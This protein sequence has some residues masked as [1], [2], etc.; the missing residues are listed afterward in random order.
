MAVTKRYNPRRRSVWAVI[1]TRNEES[2]IGPLVEAIW[3]LGVGT[4]VVD[5]G[6]VDQTYDAAREA[7]AD[8][9]MLIPDDLVPYGIGPCQRIGMRKALA[10]GAGQVV[11]I[12]AGGSHDPASIPG[13]VGALKDHDMAI[14]SRFCVGGEYL[15]GDGP[16]WRPWGSRVAAHVMNLTVHG[17]KF[18]D[19]SS[20]F[21]AFRAPLVEQ[22]IRHR[23][24]GTMYGW[25]IEALARAVESGAKI[26]EV[27][28]TYT[29]G[30]SSFKGSHVGELVQVWGHVLHHIGG[31]PK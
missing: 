10:W 19:W 6:S 25:Q 21:R 23:Y 18:S 7:G 30:E 27:P 31:S 13:L 29:A 26:A 14:G 9:V 16:R 12:D 5:D 28:I 1:T 15:R 4:V 11:T 24:V 8:E 22:L 2:S 3:T 17:A 20:G